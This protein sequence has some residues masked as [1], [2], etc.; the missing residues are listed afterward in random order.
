MRSERVNLLVTNYGPS[1]AKNVKLHFSDE[2][3]N[4]GGGDDIHSKMRQRIVN[5]YGREIS[6]IGPGQSESNTWIL[7]SAIEQKMPGAP[8]ER[9]SVTVS[10]DAASLW[11]WLPFYQK[12]HS[13]TFD[14]D[15]ER[16]LHDTTSSSSLD[17]D[18]Q[19]KQ[20]IAA[21]QLTAGHLKEI[22]ERETAA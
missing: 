4:V 17:L 14:L 16:R 3:R 15:V 7:R 11:N 20:V 9:E 12:R 13:A 19:M 21:L 10:Y 22:A 8:R 6:A 1:V 2:F 18:Q 5:K